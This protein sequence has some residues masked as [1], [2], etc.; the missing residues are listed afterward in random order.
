MLRHHS[1]QLL[2]F[3][4]QRVSRK[5]LAQV[6]NPGGVRG[7]GDA[8]HVFVQE[9]RLVCALT[10]E[11]RSPGCP[12]C[13]WQTE[14]QSSLSVRHQATQRLERVEEAVR[15]R[16]EVHE[17]MRSRE[18][19][20]VEAAGRTGLHH[21]GWV[22]LVLQHD[23]ESGQGHGHDST[24]DEDKEEEVQ[25]PRFLE[26]GETGGGSGGGG[27]ELLKFNV[28]KLKKDP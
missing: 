15:L 26:W 9:R 4:E 19:S 11:W 10:E 5:H 14:R 8:Q 13:S 17:V 2:G 1:C 16:E 22:A 20:R 6:G 27:G 12:S 24:E 7:G 3:G 21:P 23:G 28:K 25:V 18:R